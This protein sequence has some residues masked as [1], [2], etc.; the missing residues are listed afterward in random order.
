MTTAQFLRH[1]IE[2]V[3]YKIHTLLTDNGIQFTHRRQDKQ[4]RMSL[5]ERVCHEHG[6]ARRLTK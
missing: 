4:A 2:A 3:L 5:F 1:V 6:I